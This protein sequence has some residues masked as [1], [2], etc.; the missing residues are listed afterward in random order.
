MMKYVIITPRVSS[1]G[2]AQLY[3]LRR[4]LHLKRL[5]YEVHIVVA[6]HSDDYYPLKEKFD[7]IPIYIIPETGL[8]LA[9]VSKKNQEKLLT[10]LL[11]EV[12]KSESYYVESHT[13]YAVEWGEILSAKC[14]ARHLAYLLGV[15][16][17]SAYK[18]QPGLRIF[19]EKLLK[20]EFYGCSSVSLAKIFDRED[21]PSN[22]INIGYDEKEM[23]DQSVPAINY[24]KQVGDYVITTI[25][26]FDKTYI[27]P[28]A[29]AVAE[30]AHKYEKQRF[31]LLLVGSCPNQ[32]RV[33]F[34]KSN[35]NNERYKQ[36]NLDIRYL[37]YIDVL[38]KD[39]FELSDVFVGMGTASINAISQQ[40][41]TINIDP[42]GG[43][44]KASG[45]FG[46]DT[47]NFGYSENGSLYSIFSK[48]EEVFLF[49]NNRIRQI[50]DSGRALFE[51]EFEVEA[52]F[53]KLDA[54]MDS[55]E[56]TNDRPSLKVSDF[57]RLLVRYSVKIRHGLKK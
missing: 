41:I 30:L 23:A 31:V 5:G 48:I 12:G 6:N 25:T 51:N 52:C 16:P 2:G 20:G 44:T 1:M 54:V 24:S 50:K 10:N 19:D 38:G 56:K 29:D 15:Q 49:D 8:R 57:Y 34:L 28:L 21:V 46:V 3:V 45:I 53:R 47:M 32:K 55:L 43:M 35:Y 7:N 42:R 22:Y 27:E 40:C 4:S 9:Q 17:I 11:N 37:G 33:D 39:I 13:L 14:N 26:R 36:S 18:F